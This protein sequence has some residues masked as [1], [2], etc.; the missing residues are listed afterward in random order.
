MTLENLA[1]YFDKMKL[2]KYELEVCEE[3]F[4][5]LKSRLKYLNWLELVT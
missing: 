4:R 5:Q 2:T 3:I 1:Q